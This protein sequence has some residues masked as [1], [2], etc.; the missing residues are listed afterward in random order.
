MVVSGRLSDTAHDKT[1][2]ILRT[3]KYG[4]TRWSRPCCNTSAK[5]QI[6]G[7]IRFPGSRWPRF[8]KSDQPP[9]VLGKEGPTS[10]QSHSSTEPGSNRPF[11]HTAEFVRSRHRAST[12][13]PF[14][15][16]DTCREISGDGCWL[17]KELGLL[18]D[19]CRDS[20]G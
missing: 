1:L 2:A 16:L 19:V 4:Q 7:G 3:R 10:C 6:P 18:Q 12:T 15:S 20:F 14:F 11:S 8:C 9:Q 5:V 17:V 13:L